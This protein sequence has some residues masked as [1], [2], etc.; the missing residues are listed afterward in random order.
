[1]A[2][3]L[4]DYLTPHF[5]LQEF[6]LQ[7]ITTRQFRDVADDAAKLAENLD[8]DGAYVLYWSIHEEDPYNDRLLYNLGLLN[9][10]VGNYADARKFYGM[11]HQL[12]DEKRYREGLARMER[13]VAF[14][15]A[16]SQIG[17]E[18][19]EHTFQT[20]RA[21]ISAARAT[22]VEI[23]GRR[24]ERIAVYAEASEGSKVLAEVPGGVSFDLVREQGEW[25][26]IRL[27][28]G[29][30]AWIKRDKVKVKD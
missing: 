17:I 3:Q 5:E 28:G 26:C 4:A 30:E 21:L 24:E 13:N 6:E 14:A 16:L 11:A 19:A 25:V 23:K 12:K 15:E 10:V 20:S 22:E 27:L 18:I 9:E 29:E 2:P 7:K 8:V 1:M